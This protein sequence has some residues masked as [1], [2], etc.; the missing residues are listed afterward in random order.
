MNVLQSTTSTVELF[1]CNLPQFSL[2]KEPVSQ[3]IF[4]LEISN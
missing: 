2:L 3:P 4:N 1:S